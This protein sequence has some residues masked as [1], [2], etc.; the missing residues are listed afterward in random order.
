MSDFRIERDSMGELKVPADAL[1]GAQTQRAVDNFPISGLTMPRQFIRALGLIKSAAAQ[2]N[3]QQAFQNYQQSP[4]VS[5]YLNL[6]T[7]NAGAQNYQTLVRPLLEQQQQNTQTQRQINNLTAQQ[8]NLAQAGLT[9]PARGVSNQIR[10]T[11]HVAGF[12]ITG[13]YFSRPQTNTTD[14]ITRRLVTLDYSQ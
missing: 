1:Y 8:Q 14:P 4:T 10:G 9:Q 12:M 2:A 11:G 7:R 5:P 6:T 3:A 13:N